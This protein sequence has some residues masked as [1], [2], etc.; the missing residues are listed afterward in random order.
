MLA[1]KFRDSFL[2]FFQ[3]KEIWQTLFFCSSGDFFLSDAQFSWCAV[4]R[5]SSLRTYANF[6]VVFKSLL[7]SEN[8]QRRMPSIFRF[9]LNI[10]LPGAE[11]LEYIK[12]LFRNWNSSTSIELFFCAFLLQEY[13]GQSLNSCT[14]SHLKI[15][16]NK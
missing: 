1:D 4:S 13:S 10:L 16:S 2:A 11:F 8:R 14:R 12:Q 7:T 15:P 6:V 9:I 5:L 3:C